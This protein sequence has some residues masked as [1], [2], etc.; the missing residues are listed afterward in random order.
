[1]VLVLSCSRGPLYCCTALSKLIRYSQSGRIKTSS[2]FLD[3]L[4]KQLW[5]P[6]RRNR[7]TSPPDLVGTRHENIQG[8][9]HLTASEYFFSKIKNESLVLYSTLDLL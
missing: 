9:S 6:I 7:V 2:F 5:M 1:M 8:E 4:Y 3:E